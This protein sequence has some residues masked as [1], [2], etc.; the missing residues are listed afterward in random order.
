VLRIVQDKLAEK[1]FYI[2]K[3]ALMNAEPTGVSPAEEA[4]K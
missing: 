4:K 2:Q 3:P 1:K